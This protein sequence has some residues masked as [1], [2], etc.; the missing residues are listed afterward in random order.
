MLIAA[1][2]G[3]IVSIYIFVYAKEALQTPDSTQ[4]NIA[5]ILQKS[6][7]LHQ[8]FRANKS[9]QYLLVLKVDQVDEWNSNRVTESAQND[10][11]KKYIAPIRLQ[12]ALDG[13]E[14]IVRKLV[15]PMNWQYEFVGSGFG[16]PV[17]TNTFSLDSGSSYY[18]DAFIDGVSDRLWGIPA[19]LTI[20]MTLDQHRHEFDI[21][22]NAFWASLT[23]PL[24]PMTY[25]IAAFLLFRK[26]RMEQSRQHLSKPGKSLRQSG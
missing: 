18:L 10:S 23:A 21:H 8:S 3:F 22:G 20:K 4:L 7:D 5:T 13:P 1:L 17:I 25:F 19:K 9:G 15:S 11:L 14:G 12:C 24:I 26:A 16:Y 6:I 2:C